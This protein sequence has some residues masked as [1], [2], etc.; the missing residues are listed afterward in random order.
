MKIKHK[1]PGM[2][3]DGTIEINWESHSGELIERH[4]SGCW[5][6]HVKGQDI[7]SR[8]W[9]GIGDYQ[10][11]ELIDVTEPELIDALDCATQIMI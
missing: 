9:E 5:V 2:S 11:D 3:F 4:D 1:I 8:N 10:G 7:Y 6:G